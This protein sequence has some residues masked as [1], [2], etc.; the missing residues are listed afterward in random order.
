M[1]RRWTTG[2][3]AAW[4]FDEVGEERLW[5]G[6]L[7]MVGLEGEESSDADVVISQE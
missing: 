7:G 4:A 6:S 3:L 2:G 1:R 5:R